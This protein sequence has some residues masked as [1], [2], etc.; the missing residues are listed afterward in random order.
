MK[1]HHRFNSG[2][3]DI[4]IRG[5]RGAQPP[6]KDISIPIVVPIKYKVSLISSRFLLVSTRCF[7]LHYLLRCTI[8]YGALHGQTLSRRP[9]SHV[10]CGL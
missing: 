10:P 9:M 5:V 3:F 8:Y 4:V 6:N 2:D 7:P 1:P